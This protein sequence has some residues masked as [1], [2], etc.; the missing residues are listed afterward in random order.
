MRKATILAMF[1]FACSE[2]IS[3]SDAPDAGLPDAPPLVCEDN[4]T[5]CGENCLDL[6]TDSMHCGVCNQACSEGADNCAFGICLCGSSAAC[7]SPAE[8]ID[9]LCNYPDENGQPC[10]FDEECKDGEFCVTGFCTFPACQH[11]KCNSEDDDCN[12]LPDD[13]YTCVLNSTEPCVSACNTIGLKTCVSGGIDGECSWGACLPPAESCNS[14][15]DDCDGLVDNGFDCIPGDQM[16]CWAPNCNG[17]GQMTC[18]AD[19][20]WGPCAVYATDFCDGVDNDCDDEID[21][22]DLAVYCYTGPAGTELNPPCQE[23]LRLCVNGQFTDECFFEVLPT[24]EAGV[25]FC[26]GLDNDCDT[27]VDGLIQDGTC[28]PF[29]PVLFDIVFVIDVSGSM[30]GYIQNVK[31]AV[32]QLAA[33]FAGNTNFL[34][35]LVEFG[36]TWPDFGQG[37]ILTDLVEFTEFQMVLNNDLGP[38][39]GGYEPSYDVI[40]DLASGELPISWR[41][42]S[43]RTI[44]VI[45]DEEAQTAYGNTETDMCD[46]LQSGEI[47]AIV[48]STYLYNGINYCQGYDEC[49]PADLCFDINTSPVTMLANLNTIFEAGCAQ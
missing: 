14:E 17:E 3:P 2:S 29:D 18:Q 1:F 20:S 19:C 40:I 33:Q 48:T 4:L 46:S 22:D 15:D 27:C 34:F 12:G 41:A 44:I 36:D 7:L 45:G 11:E 23:G 9:E 25:F 47:L 39:D 38:I 35:A 21:E 37:E 13:I 30:G 26:D 49:V 42:S 43:T 32:D 5:A 6:Q 24:N 28:Q 16:D 31:I 10:E 8:C